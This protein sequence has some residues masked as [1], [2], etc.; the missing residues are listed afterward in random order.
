VLF[1]NASNYAERRVVSASPTGQ[2]HLTL[3]TGGWFLYLENPDGSHA[4][5]S[6]LDVND[7]PEGARVVLVSR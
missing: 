1:V 3:P 4:Y 7:R 6:R 2:F 5:H